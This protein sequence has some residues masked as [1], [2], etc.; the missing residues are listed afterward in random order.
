[1]GFILLYIVSIKPCKKIEPYLNRR[2]PS[3]LEKASIVVKWHIWKLTYTIILILCLFRYTVNKGEY[4][5][6]HVLKRKL[7]VYFSLT[8]NVSPHHYVSLF[9]YSLCVLLVVCV[10]LWFLNGMKTFMHVPSIPHLALNPGKIE[11]AEKGEHKQNSLWEHTW[12]NAFKI[13]WI[14]SM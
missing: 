13:G 5:W 7:L 10:S 3:R 6:W 11:Y 2:G 12:R 8:S 9:F 14:D 4:K 1:M